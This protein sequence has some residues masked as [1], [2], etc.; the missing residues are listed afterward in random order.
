MTIFAG[1]LLFNRKKKTSGARPEVMHPREEAQA[2]FV[3]IF[4]TALIEDITLAP[5]AHNRRPQHLQRSVPSSLSDFGL[6]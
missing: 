5:L 4:S 2:Y 1:F 3:G 6:R